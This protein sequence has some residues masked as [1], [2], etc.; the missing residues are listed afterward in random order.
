MERDGNR[1]D[2]FI[3]SSRGNSPKYY[4]GSNSTAKRK[5]NFFLDGKSENISIHKDVGANKASA[6]GPNSPQKY[7]N[8]P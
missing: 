8:I 1:L 2:K 3:V 7:F 5:Q 4:V 6:D